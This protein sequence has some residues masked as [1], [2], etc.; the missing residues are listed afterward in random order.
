MRR[1]APCRENARRTLP[2]SSAKKNE[3]ANAK[4]AGRVYWPCNVVSVRV[5]RGS[6]IPRR[7]LAARDSDFA[8]KRA[9]VT[10]PGASAVEFKVALQV[11][12]GLGGA[13]NFGKHHTEIV[14]GISKI[15]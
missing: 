8:E 1:V 9:G 7:D 3:P 6:D 2:K 15:G 11:C 5:A 13:A 10:G 12:A 4:L 14:V